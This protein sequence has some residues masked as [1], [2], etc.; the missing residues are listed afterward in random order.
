MSDPKSVNLYF[1]E[2]SSDKVYNAQLEKDPAGWSVN[3]QYGRRNKPLKA[4]NKGSGM[5]Y[6]TAY[7]VYEK[8]V[9]TKTKKGYTEEVSGA[10][11]SSSEFA[12]QATGFRPQLLNEITL[13]EA[14]EYG[15]MWL[16]QEKHDGERRGL[17]CDGE[18][19]IFS[20]RS[21]LEVGVQ[22][23]IDAAFAKLAEIVGEPLAL[24]AEDMGDHVVIFDVLEHF[25][26][27]DGT[28][29]ERAAILAHLD[30]TI[31]DAGLRET[32]IVDIPTPAPHFLKHHLAGLQEAKAEGFVLRHV[33]S[34]NTPGKPASGG[35]ALKVKFW[36]DCTCRVTEGR[37]GK[38]S[39]GIELM[40]VEGNWTAVG[41]VTVPQGQKPDIGSLIDVKYL[42]AFKGGS[43][44]QP[45]F[46]GIRTDIPEADCVMTQ[47]KYKAGEIEPDQSDSPSP[48]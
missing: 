46:K 38:S 5:D 14:E 12:G 10:V 42:Y 45:S 8:L 39:V 27:K 11:F 35:E 28:F 3:F 20:N 31:S 47:L 29:R 34:I 13:I 2:G 17:K 32:L 21:G 15:E 25:M 19:N 37:T 30:K 18:R 1:T 26:I 24:D 44:F 7:G 33:D 6:E 40:D 22:E 41:N 9:G 4:G 23:P 16:A 43:L 48:C 36:A